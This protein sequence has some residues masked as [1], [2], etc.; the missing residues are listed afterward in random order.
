MVDYPGVVFIK[1]PDQSTSLLY[2]LMPSPVLNEPSQRHPEL[3][4]PGKILGAK[5]GLDFYANRKKF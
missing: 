5:T 3:F 2:Y 1:A 4:A